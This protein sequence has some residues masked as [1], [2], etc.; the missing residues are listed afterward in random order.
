MADLTLEQ[1]DYLD[2]ESLAEETVCPKCGNLYCDI[3]FNFRIQCDR[4]GYNS[5]NKRTGCK[6][7]TN[8]LTRYRI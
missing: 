3:D 5:R 6:K 7:M 2:P 1:D 4:C 8:N